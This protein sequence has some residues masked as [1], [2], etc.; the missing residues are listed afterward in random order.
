MMI[1][2]TDDG[3]VLFAVPWQQKIVVGTTDT[4]IH[5][6]DIEPK[7]LAEEIEFILAHFNR[8]TNASI[9]RQDVKSVFVGLRP[10]VKSNNNGSTALL[11]RDHTLVVSPSR[12]VSIT[13]GKWTT[14]R[15]M[16]QDAIDNALFVSKQTHKNPCRTHTL[17]IGN[18][19]EK[20]SAI[21]SII[22][23]R[24]ELAELLHLQYHYIKAEVVYAT[25][26][27]MAITVEDFL[28]RRIR[29]LFLDAEAAIEIVDMV[30]T[31]MANELHKDSNWA[32]SQKHSFETLAQ[33][34]LLT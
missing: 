31:L 10:L 27:E 5:I 23:D 28:A 33:Q 22:K 13:G 29:L 34:Y 9:T 12:L 11:S 32:L 26:Y 6:I 24:P 19:S 7:P 30:A 1:P 15:K 18:E 2:K 20:Q 21:Q 16:G 25:R 14:Y 3:R 17:A 4:P 8:Y